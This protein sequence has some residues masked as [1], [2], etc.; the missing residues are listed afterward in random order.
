VPDSDPAEY[1]A[2]VTTGY[3][4]YQNATLTDSDS[5][6]VGYMVPKIRNSDGELVSI[7]STGEPDGLRLRYRL[8]V[9]SITSTSAFKPTATERRKNRPRQSFPATQAHRTGRQS[10]PSRS[11]NNRLITFATTLHP[12][13]RMATT[14]S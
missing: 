12:A 2:T 11:R 3:V 14:T 5:G 6:V 7:E 10:W 4:C 8:R 9:W 1:Q 13:K